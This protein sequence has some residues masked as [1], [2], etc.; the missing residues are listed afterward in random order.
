MK[1]VKNK[2]NKK[3]YLS[4]ILFIFI[5]IINILSFL[6]LNSFL[7]K[8]TPDCYEKYFIIFPKNSLLIS[9]LWIGSS[10]LIF[11]F[12]IKIIKQN[13]HF[14]NDKTKLILLYIF[15]ICF[16]IILYL[17]MDYIQKVYFYNDELFKSMCFPTV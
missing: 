15:T 7:E 8:R 10:S 11:L 16:G 14:K 12:I 1:K 13:I 4:Y 3:N 5:V 17:A 2:E 6:K 9:I